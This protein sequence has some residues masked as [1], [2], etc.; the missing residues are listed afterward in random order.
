[1]KDG[2]EKFTTL[3]YTPTDEGK[4]RL[5]A[6]FHY[7]GD[8]RVWTVPAGFV[9]DLDSVFRI[10]VIYALFK[11]RTT[12]AAV[13]HDWWWRT[14]E[15]KA[16]SDKRFLTAMKHEGVRWYFRYPIYLAVA[17]LGGR[18]YRNHAQRPDY[19]EER[20]SEY[21]PEPRDSGHFAPKRRAA[22]RHGRGSGRSG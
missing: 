8:D 10:P 12:R 13:F 5:T 16:L 14:Q 15:P 18:I 2:R 4:Y 20:N 19:H 9:T 7:N 21:T 17:L 1:M 6:D 11:G 3:H 22:S